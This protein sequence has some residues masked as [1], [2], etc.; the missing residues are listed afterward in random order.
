MIA[1]VIIFIYI[2]PFIFCALLG[3]YSNDVEFLDKADNDRV[4]EYVGFSMIPIL[5]IVVIVT[6]IFYITKDYI[7]GT[8][9]K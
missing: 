7:K 3:R 9:T 2:L 4:N 1:L 5:N 6:G 8:G